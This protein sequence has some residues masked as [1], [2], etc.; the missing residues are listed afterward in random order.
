MPTVYCVAVFL[1]G[2][3]SV[4]LHAAVPTVA[5]VGTARPTGRFEHPANGF[6][7]AR[8]T[9]VTVAL[10]MSPANGSKAGSPPAAVMSRIVA[11]SA[12]LAFGFDCDGVTNELL[13]VYAERASS[14]P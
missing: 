9:K 1:F 8:L 4:V 12:T 13:P 10:R 11:E 7:V 5:S 2:A 6:P 3:V 14:W